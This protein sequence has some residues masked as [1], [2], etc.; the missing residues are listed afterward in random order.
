MHTFVVLWEVCWCADLE[1]L[2][3]FACKGE[4][5][6]DYGYWK[7]ISILEERWQSNPAPTAMLLFDGQEFFM[8]L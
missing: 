4:I 2:D 1:A 5:S 3:T 6:I 8:M 7:T